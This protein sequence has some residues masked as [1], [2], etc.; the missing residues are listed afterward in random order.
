M[1]PPRGSLMLMRACR[2]PFWPITRCQGTV[3]PARLSANTTRRAPRGD[4]ASAA[5]WPYVT[6]RPRGMRASTAAMR[7][8]EV[9]GRRRDGMAGA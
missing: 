2:G 5:T 3:G 1:R 9:F 4:P 6:T 8:D 7:S